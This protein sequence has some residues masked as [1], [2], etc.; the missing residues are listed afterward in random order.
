[1]KTL[2]SHINLCSIISQL[3]FSLNI[4]FIY[5]LICLL[6]IR[7]SSIRIHITC[8]IPALDDPEYKYQ[9]NHH[10]Y[11]YRKHDKPLNRWYVSGPTIAYDTND[12][13]AAVIAYGSCVAT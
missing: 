5:N 6:R 9:K 3:F 7:Y 12:M 10:C 1:M 11:E 8:R 13:I 4:P 2:L